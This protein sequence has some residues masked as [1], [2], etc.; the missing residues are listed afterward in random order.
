MVRYLG[1][2]P[3][4]EFRDYPPDQV[5]FS[6]TDR[7]GI[8]EIA[9]STFVRLARFSPE[10]LIGAPH[11]I[12]RHP[13]MPGAAFHIMWER[14]L[15]GKPMMAYVKNL[16]KDGAYYLTFSTVTPLGDGFIS[17]RCAITRHDL[18]GPVSEIY[19]QTLARELEWR[20]GGAS[21]AEAARLGA[22][23]LASRLQELGFPTY[24]DVIHALV[25]AEVDE[26]RRLAPPTPPVTTPGEP[27]HNVVRAIVGLDRELGELRS[28]FENADAVA[29]ELVAA[30]DRLATHLDAL[31]HAA[32]RAAV[33]AA[34]VVHQAPAAVKS[35]KAAVSLSGQAARVMAPLAESLADV[36]WNVLELRTALALSV[37]HNDMAMIFAREARE[38][39]GVAGHA[40]TVLELGRTVAHSVIAG[41]A[42]R[43][44]VSAGLSA[45]ADSIDEAQET[46]LAF[47]RMLTNWRF[48][49]VRSGVSQQLGPLVDP[50]DRRLTEGLDEMREL[51][52]L[53]RQC[54]HLGASIDAS[55]LQVAASRLVAAASAL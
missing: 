4:G 39:I 2:E 16:A 22:A 54:R 48:V 1:L 23:D 15:A 33:A 37:L 20:A 28:R 29:T 25:P 47:Q 5:F 46:L 19:A 43:Q 9:N 41:E 3:T 36:R 51:G 18:W 24:D 34:T 40:N 32:D 49:V 12:I 26:R 27:L 14:L 6:T 31:A 7:K 53:A 44:R 11:N 13:D 8:I 55:T 21:A 35:A 30:K 52:A 10:E 50:I 42:M 17:V 38:G 45:I